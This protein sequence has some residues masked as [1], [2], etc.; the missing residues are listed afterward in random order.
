M[1]SVLKDNAGQASA[2]NAGFNASRGEIVIF[3][4]ADDVL[5]PE[6][7]GRVSDVF[8][9]RPDRQGALPVS[10]RG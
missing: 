3:L 9:Q 1:K 10:G 4:D 6:T 2:F 7:V 5:L 8:V